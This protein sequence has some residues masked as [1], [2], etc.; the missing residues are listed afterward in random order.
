LFARSAQRQHFIS[1]TRS[2]T[3]DP[4]TFASLA[5]E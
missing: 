5:T 3:P 2:G 4:Q 1:Q